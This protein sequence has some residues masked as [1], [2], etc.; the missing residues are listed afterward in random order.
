MQPGVQR[1]GNPTCAPSGPAC[2]APCS[3]PV[4][5]CIDVADDGTVTAASSPTDEPLIF[6]PPGWVK[7]DE[8]FVPLSAR[9]VGSSSWQHRCWLV[10]AAELAQPQQ[11]SFPLPQE[12]LPRQLPVT[13]NEAPGCPATRNASRGAQ[14]RWREALIVTLCTAAGATLAAL[15]AVYAW[16]CWTHGHCVRLADLRGSPSVAG[17]QGSAS[18]KATK[19]PA[20]LSTSGTG[21]LGDSGEL[22]APA[23]A[24]ALTGAPGWNRQLRPAA[25][26]GRC[27]ASAEER[28]PAQACSP[29][30]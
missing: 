15:V 2:L 17:S 13:D 29:R 21:K 5:A 9:P 30:D 3:L 20:S 7:S 4:Q 28:Q 12:G 24:A 1:Q 8:F 26:V 22:E 16:T 19:G 11:H 6:V 23:L 27:H 14:V 18:A 10:A 25:A